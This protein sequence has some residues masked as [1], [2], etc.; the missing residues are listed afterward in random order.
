MI[1]S[2]TG[3]GRG[4]ASEGGI[5]VGVELRSVNSRFLEISARLP[6]SLSSRENEIKELVRTR[7]SR[8]KINVLVNVERESNGAIPVKVNTPAVK[9]YYRLLNDLKKSVRLRETVKLAHL[10]EFSEVFQSVDD[11]S[12]EEKEW[13]V[14][15]SG[16]LGALEELTTMRKQEGKELESDF[17]QRIGVLQGHLDE[18]ERLSRDQV[19]AERKRLRERIAQLLESE[20]IEI[21]QRARFR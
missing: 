7:I 18:V 15:R 8:G 5:T 14:A 3:Y 1:T 9:A 10:L 17:R 13:L 19:P 2:M 6:R 16:I 20:S 12:S 11:E 21:Q 4:E